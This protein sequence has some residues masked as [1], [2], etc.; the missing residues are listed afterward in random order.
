MTAILTR[1]VKVTTVYSCFI[2]FCLREK[3]LQCNNVEQGNEDLQTLMRCNNDLVRLLRVLTALLQNS[4][5]PERR[6][7]IRTLS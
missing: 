7:V 6:E 2:E 1:S 5:T 3:I 4:K